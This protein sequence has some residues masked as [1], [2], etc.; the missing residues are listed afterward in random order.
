MVRAFA[1]QAR[2]LHAA[3]GDVLGGDDAY[4]DAYHAVF[5]SFADPENS[6]DIAAVKITGQTKL[7]VVGGIEGFLFGFELEDRCERT[8]CFFFGTQHV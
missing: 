2:L 5:Q 1:A 7:C 6:A 8:K 4:V 3:K